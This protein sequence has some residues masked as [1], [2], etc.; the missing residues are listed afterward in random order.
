MKEFKITPIRS[1][2]LNVDIDKIKD[3]V[4]NNL[5]YEEIIEINKRLDKEFIST[6]NCI[7]HSVHL[8]CP[9]VHNCISHNYILN[10]S[11]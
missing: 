11:S 10:S 6:H 1:S 8:T 3:N 7:S 2:I 4:Y 9:H 5:S